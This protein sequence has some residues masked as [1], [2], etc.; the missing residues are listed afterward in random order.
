MIDLN[1]FALCWTIAFSDMKI[2]A[3]TTICPKPFAPFRESPNFIPDCPG[4]TL[5]S[6]PLLLPL[7]LFVSVPEIF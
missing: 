6:R 2:R 5:C 3:V 1:D 4:E 7:L